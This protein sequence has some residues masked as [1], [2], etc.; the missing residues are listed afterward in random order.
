MRHRLSAA[1]VLPAVLALSAC[2]SA[3]AEG[4][5]TVAV[6]A[7]DGACEVARTSVPAGVV[8]FTV[9]NKGSGATELYVYDAAGTTI[10]S[11]V[12][13]VGPG[14]TRDLVVELPGGSA[15]VG[16]RPDDASDLVRTEVSVTASGAT[17]AAST[18]PAIA[19][20]V[21]RYRA[22]VATESDAL[23]A[24]T[25]DFVAAVK[26]G[27]VATAKALYPQ[28]RTH[29]ERIEPV[30]EVFADLDPAL[31]ARENDVEPGI[32]WTGWH[33][34]E[35]ALWVDGSTAGMAAVAD[36]LLADTTTLVGLI[37]T[38][39]LTASNLG[40]GAA[41]LLEEVAEG[42]V[43]GEE[44]RYSRTDLWDF[45]ANVEGAYEAY[46]ALADVLREKDAGLD[47]TL[48]T[49]FDA[50]FAELAKHSDGDGFVGYDTLTEAQVRVLADKV[51]ALAEPLSR[52][53]ATV[54]R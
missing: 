15:V 22:Y 17:S 21:E 31:D 24:A 44:E 30:A 11:E 50:L 47:R 42:K 20:A 32:D 38:V 13:N 48:S 4:S 41:A 19:A 7:G 46:D 51:D 9:T 8:T 33:R 25:T 14:V 54:V 1:L 3:T 52:V 26:A 27:D 10:L 35:K 28:A 39:T 37:P 40:N 53:T 36:K 45:Q 2:S 18:S 23:L 6:T 16:C 5:A 34:I 43:T 12:E 49:R 29:W